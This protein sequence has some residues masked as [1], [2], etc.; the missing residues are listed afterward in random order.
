MNLAAGVY[1]VEGPSLR[2]APREALQALDLTPAP[3]PSGPQRALLSCL[4]VS[5]NAAGSTSTRRLRQRRD[6]NGLRYRPAHGGA[7]AEFGGDGPSGRR[8]AIP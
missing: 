3:R 8:S 6:R 2:E 1:G 7:V 5:L 4:I